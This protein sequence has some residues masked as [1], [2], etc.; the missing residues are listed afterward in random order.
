[1]DSLALGS[2]VMTLH[3]STL[4]SFSLLYEW[5]RHNYQHQHRH[6]LDP[7][8]LQC[9]VFN[10]YIYIYLVANVTTALF[11]AL[12]FKQNGCVMYIYHILWNA[13]IGSGTILVDFL[14]RSS[15][16]QVK[17]ARIDMFHVLGLRTWVVFLKHQRRVIWLSL[18][19]DGRKVTL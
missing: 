10:I 19:K 3:C 17:S 12:I 6:S 2:G 7:L 8:E 18:H 13:W 15:N 4:N 9:R 5:R 11:I 16:P 1:M 14:T